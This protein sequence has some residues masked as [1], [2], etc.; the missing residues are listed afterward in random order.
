MTSP[1]YGITI[2]IKNKQ[3]TTLEIALAI[4]LDSQG[5]L[6]DMTTLAST[7]RCPHIHTIDQSL[8]I[9]LNK[10]ELFQ[11]CHRAA[12]AISELVLPLS[13]VLLP[14]SPPIPYK[15]IHNGYQLGRAPAGLIPNPSN[16][17]SFRI[18]RCRARTSSQ[19]YM[20]KKPEKSME[21]VGP[22]HTETVIEL[23]S[24]GICP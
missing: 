18:F 11:T 5:H 19:V 3:F 16:L 8:R 15:L 17:P 10:L 1:S 22:S 23:P 6:Y 21:S 13:R 12:R 20:K 9:E 4:S 7:P 2:S 24:S 14:P